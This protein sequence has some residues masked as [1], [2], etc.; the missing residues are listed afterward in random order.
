MGQDHLTTQRLTLRPVSERDAGP[1]ARLIGD[2]AVAR[3]L[4]HVPHPYAEA[5]AVDFIARHRDAPATYAI[6]LANALIG[7]VSLRAELGYWLGVPYWGRGYATEAARA[8][9]AAHFGARGTSVRSG[10]HEGNDASRNVLTKLGFV[11]DGVD[12]QTVRSL[13]SSVNVLKMRLTRAAWRAA[14]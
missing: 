6:T 5:D 9:L 7:C 12:V 1:I 14:A 8:V 3:W 4:T 11:P 13:G 2:L 10:Y